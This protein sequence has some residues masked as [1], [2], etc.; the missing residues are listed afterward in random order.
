M[1]AR[2]RADVVTTTIMAI[3]VDRFRAW[4]RGEP[5]SL[6]AIHD[7]IERV[8]RDEFADCAREARD[9]FKLADD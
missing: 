5:L 7:Q 9:D 4:L 6:K 8:L 3:I 2:D 1:T